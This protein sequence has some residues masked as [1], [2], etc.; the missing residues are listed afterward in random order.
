MFLRKRLQVTDYWNECH[1]IFSKSAKLFEVTAVKVSLRSL[2]FSARYSR[3]T[4]R[5]YNRHPIRARINKQYDTVSKGYGIGYESN[6]LEALDVPGTRLKAFHEKI[7]E[8]YSVFTWSFHKSSIRY[9]PL[10]ERKKT[11][12]NAGKMQLFSFQDAQIIACRQ[13][14]EDTLV[15][16]S[17]L[18]ETE[19]F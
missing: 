1:E 3:K 2:A 18:I 14:Y 5:V 9:W 17:C 13:S 12:I 8:K 7:Q 10:E 4:E 15:G 6:F 11:S 19:S 16:G